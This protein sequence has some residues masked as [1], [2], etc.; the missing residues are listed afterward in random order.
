[1]LAELQ[2]DVAHRRTSTIAVGGAGVD[3]M[4]PGNVT[5][6]T[7]ET[8]SYDPAGRLVWTSGQVAVDADGQ[9]PEGWE[10]QTRLVFENVEANAPSGDSSYR[11]ATHTI[12][13]LD[14]QGVSN[15]QIFATG[16]PGNVPEPATWAMM[17]MGFGVTGAAMRRSRRKLALAQIA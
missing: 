5:D 12:T 3:T 1:M 16:T 6:V 13:L 4:D 9:V 2:V 15:A 8:R 17:L 10:A 11:L 14:G 7:L